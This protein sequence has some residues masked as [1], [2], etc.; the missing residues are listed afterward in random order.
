MTVL[1]SLK[2]TYEVFFSQPNSFLVIILQLPVGSRLETR[3]FAS[4]YR[5]L[6]L[7][8]LCQS[9]NYFTTGGLPP[10]SSSWCQ[11]P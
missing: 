10:I 3:L 4:D 7:L 2:I 1:L 8:L 5:S 6:L 9:E 11:A